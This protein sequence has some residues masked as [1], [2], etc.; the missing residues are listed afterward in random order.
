MTVD[1]SPPARARRLAQRP[2]ALPR[3][4]RNRMLFGGLPLSA[5][6]ETETAPA[7][8]GR[9]SR[10]DGNDAKAGDGR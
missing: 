10:E 3:D 4:P 2:P 7:P 9:V 8:F 5:L 1:E 6:P